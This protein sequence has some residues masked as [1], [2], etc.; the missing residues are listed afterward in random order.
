MQT[1]AN[2]RS[3]LD[4]AFRKRVEEVIRKHEG[5]HVLAGG[6]VG[7]S[8]FVWVVGPGQTPSGRRSKKLFKACFGSNGLDLS[9]GFEEELRRIPG[10]QG[11]SIN[12]D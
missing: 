11:H 7:V 3:T 9:N 10:Y 2:R 1:T 5:L 8:C 12:L 4:P 6:G